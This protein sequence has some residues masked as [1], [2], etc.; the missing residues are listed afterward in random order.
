MKRSILIF[1]IVL[2]TGCS[3]IRVYSDFDSEASFSNYT[4]FAFFKEGVDQVSISDLDK[5][6]ILKSIDTLLTAKGLSKSDTPDLLININTKAKERISVYSNNGWGWG[7]GW[8]PWFWGGPQTQ[9]VSSRTEG[10]LYIDMIDR[11]TNQLVWQGIGKGG[12]QESMKNRDQRIATFV[13]EIL[14]QFPPNQE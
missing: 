10:T 7:W 11:K 6:R 8:N 3:S 2:T 5:R 14:K 12:I 4:S 9:T 13:A 1:L